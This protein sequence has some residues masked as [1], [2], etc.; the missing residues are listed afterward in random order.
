MTDNNKASKA[1]SAWIAIGHG[2]VIDPTLTPY[3]LRLK[4]ERSFYPAI[5][6]D[7]WLLILNSVNHMK[8]RG[9]R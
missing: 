5:A 2:L 6:D 8:H 1:P 4:G 9:N 3:T 7:D